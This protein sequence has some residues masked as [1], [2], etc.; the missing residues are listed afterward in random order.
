MP[1][2]NA[3]IKMD[4]TAIGAVTGGT[5][6]T[7]KSLGDSLKQHDIHYGGGTS[8]NRNTISF[9]SVE[10][11]ASSGA[12]G[13]TTQERSSLIV[14]VPLTLANDAKTTNSL[15]ISLSVDPETTEADRLDLMLTGAQLLGNTDFAAFWKDRTM[16]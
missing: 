12:P 3:I 4:A 6:E 15:R 2:S 5:S 10:H 16:T 11:Q 9:E 1:I 13:G 8:L 14:R 7:L